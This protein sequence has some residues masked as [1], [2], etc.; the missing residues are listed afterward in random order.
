MHVKGILKRERMT[1]LATQIYR[2]RQEYAIISYSSMDA[3]DAG[4]RWARAD[5][6]TGRN[7]KTGKKRQRERERGSDR[8]AA[9][10]DDDVTTE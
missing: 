6:W 9:R 3:A 8:A 1:K 10:D 2:P 7:R 5:F 4:G